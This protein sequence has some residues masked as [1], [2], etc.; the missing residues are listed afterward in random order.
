[1]KRFVC[2]SKLLNFNRVL[3]LSPH[4]DDVELGMIG[5]ILKYEDTIFDILCLSSCGAK[6]F[7]NT[8]QLDRR[9]EVKDLWI[10]S[11]ND[12][13]NT[14]FANVEY[15]EDKSEFE[16]INYIETTFMR[17]NDCIFIPS[18]E[19]SMLE[20]RFVNKFG[21]ALIRHLPISLIEYHTM[22]SLNS[23]VPNL[24]VDI[25]SYY[26][27]KSKLLLKHFKSQL[28]RKYFSDKAL[29]AN[30]T[31]FQSIKKGIDMVEK[32]KIKEIMS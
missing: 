26:T 1:M 18:Y 27:K 12:N 5:T 7:D 2:M 31:N 14:L 8:S 20:H 4:P 28:H 6:G 9:K 29:Y 15:F 16:W 10:D 30:N 17:D 3:C 22:S 23:W 25:T 24:C 19:D 21:Y 32:Y 11:G 13:V